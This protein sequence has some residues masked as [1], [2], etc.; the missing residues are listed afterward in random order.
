MISSEILHQ[1]SYEHSRALQADARMA[2]R[3][4]RRRR[5][6]PCAERRPVLLRWTCRPVPARAQPPA[7]EAA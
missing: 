3:G 4:R 5:S 2:G 1:L 6:G 7:V